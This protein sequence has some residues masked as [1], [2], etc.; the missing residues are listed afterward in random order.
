MDDRLSRE[1]ML[2]GRAAVAR[3]ASSHV[4]VFGL[5]GVGGMAAEAL[6]R[7][8]V[9]N[10]TLIDGDVVA[11]SNINRQIVALTST[12]GKPKAEV[13]AQRVLDINP[14]ARVRAITECYTADTRER[15]MAD[16]DYIIDAIDTVTHKLD[17][18]ETAV[19]RGIPILSSM[20]TGNKLDASRLRVCD[21]YDTEGCPL[22]RVMRRELRKR[23]IIA[24]RVVASTETP[25]V[26]AED[27]GSVP[28]S[29][30][31]VPPAAGL[32]LAGEVIKELIKCE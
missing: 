2:L 27:H 10:L 16:Y 20:G 23:G 18:I 8:G 5:G 29:V 17:L 12:V 4:A 1:I 6:A 30:S 24:L 3:L 31:W 22:A 9:C 7:A 14:D 13:M 15:F 26:R 11:P 19:R 32:M 28:G 21:V 25:A